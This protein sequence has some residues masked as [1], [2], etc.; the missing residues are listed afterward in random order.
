MT[1]SLMDQLKARAC[2]SPKTVVF[3]EG[4]SP[5]IIEAAA[6]AAAEGFAF[7]V[8]VGNP[9]VIGD[10]AAHRGL[11]LDGVAIRP[12]PDETEAEAL[13]AA[14]LEAG[15]ML[16]RK[17][18]LRRM[19]SPMYFGALLVA[20][21]QG[22]AMVA[23]LEHST[24]EVVLA[25][26]TIIGFAEGI[27]TP[28]SICLMECPGFAGPEGELLIFADPGV[29]EKPDVSALADIAISSARTAKA[30]LNW[31][32]RVAFLSFSTK[33]SVES[34]IIDLQ[35][36]A[37]EEVRRR[38]PDLKVDGELQFDAAIVPDVARKKVPEGSDVAGAANVLVFPDLNAGNICYKA[39]QRLT[40]G[41]AYGP[42]LQGFAKTVSDLSR[43][44][45][46]DDILGVT[47][48]AVLNSQS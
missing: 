31:E 4:E 48:M 16:S 37:L 27:S 20:S 21:G 33:G 7:P 35:L 47:V 45:S 42:F 39:A 13:A 46:V 12:L 26:S 1:A 23:G 44:S 15:G 22:D 40:G 30:L 2:E 6:Q 9:Q 18:I 38:E 11:S 34:E 36:K 3:P 29:C 17:G 32:P 24:A 8:L 28:S 5:R 41:N 43:G 14:Y 10:I 19:K 25:S